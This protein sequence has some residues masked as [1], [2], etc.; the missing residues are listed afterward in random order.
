MSST[1]KG[2]AEL[3]A[4]I[5]HV[6]SDR[7]VF[8]RALTH[9]SFSNEA[10]DP[11]EHNERLEFLGDAVVNTVVS[12]AAYRLFPDADEGELTRLKS[13]VVA[14]PCL[15]RRAEAI[16]LG[17]YLLLGRGAAGQDGIS[18]NPSVLSDA[19]EALVGALFIDAGFLVA[20][21][22]VNGHLVPELERVKAEHA[23]VDP[24]TA[25]QIACL[26]QF[27]V[28]PLYEVA[29]RSGPSH[30]PTF[31]VRVVLPK[32]ESFEAQAGS[33]KAGEQ[34]AATLALCSMNESEHIDG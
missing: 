12:I 27:H 14:R 15:A 30:G 17:D 4:T 26:R 16:H 34:A 13:V 29:A 20:E 10:T 23:E 2:I 5:G 28:A 21:A 11:V 9:T 31:T 6:F 22:F 24:K 19:F 25:L 32:G 8:M 33:R 3:E 1:K 7:A 18:T